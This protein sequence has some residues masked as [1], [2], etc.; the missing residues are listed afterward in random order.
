MHAIN[1]TTNVA[2][3]AKSYLTFGRFDN[4]NHKPISNEDLSNTCEIVGVSQKD[5]AAHCP[6]VNCC[7]C[8]WCKKGTRCQNRK[9]K[10]KK[11][12]IASNST[13]KGFSF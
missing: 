1:S 3:Q 4:H 7:M 5:T 8:V 2:P 12:K 13:R 6:S 9:T 10:R 11:S